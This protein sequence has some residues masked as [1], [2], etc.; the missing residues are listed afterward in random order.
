MNI[1]TV[2]LLFSTFVSWIAAKPSAIVYGASG[3]LASAYWIPGLGSR[4]LSNAVHR[5][6]CSLKKHWTMP[7]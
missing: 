4:T 6:H 2:N 5:I 7:T 1:L 3:Y